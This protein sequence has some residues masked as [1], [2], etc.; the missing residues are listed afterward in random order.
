MV[1]EERERDRERWEDKELLL[2]LPPLGGSWRR[3]R[4][5]SQEEKLP[6]PGGGGTCA[7][8]GLAGALGTLESSS[9]K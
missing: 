7:V 4:L 2:D 8:L 6:K 9:P 1:C 3:S 5:H